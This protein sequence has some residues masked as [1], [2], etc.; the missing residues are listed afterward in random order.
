MRASLTAVPIRELMVTPVVSLTPDLSLEEA[1]NRYFLPYGYSGFPVVQES[2]LLGLVTVADVQAIPIS[3]WPSI[4]VEEIMRTID[5]ESTIGPDMSMMQ[6]VD[7][8][9]QQNIERLIVVENG[10]VVGLVTRSAIAHFA[11]QYQA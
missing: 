11:H 8:M 6:A 3:R 5:E 10:F 1:V 2:R 4:R 9:I 7:R